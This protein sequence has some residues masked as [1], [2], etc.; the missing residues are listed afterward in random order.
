MNFLKLATVV[1]TLT[2]FAQT[3]SAADLGPN[4]ALNTDVKATYLWDAQTT[5]ATVNPELS[6]TGLG[7]LGL[8]VG[9]TL[10]L[11]ENVGTKS[12][13]TDEW[14]HLPVLEFGASYAVN[15]SLGLD[16]SFNYDLETKARGDIKLVA[17]FS[18]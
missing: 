9:T 2:G 18:F 8:T 3:T 10:N 6:Y 7:N 14:N 5:V 11:W 1:A 16:G 13:I 4:L 17:T 12:D 15:S